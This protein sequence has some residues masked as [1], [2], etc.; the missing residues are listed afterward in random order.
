MNYLG[1]LIQPIKTFMKINKITSDG[2]EGKLSFS[3][4]YQ[5]ELEF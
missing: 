1:S 3:S 2:M 4:L 5:I